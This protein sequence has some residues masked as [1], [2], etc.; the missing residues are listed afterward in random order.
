MHWKISLMVLLTGALIPI[1][2]GINGTL[3]RKT[4]NPLL[5]ATASFVIGTIFLLAVF[6]MFGGQLPKLSSL[7][8]EPWW[9]WTGGAVGALYVLLIILAV[10]RTGAAALIVFVVA[11]QMIASLVIDHYGLIGFPPVPISPQRIFGALLLIGG[12]LV[13]RST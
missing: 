8:G 12:V 9:I 13:I 3:A 6:P 7:R 5:A 10:Q 4:G 2:A 1:Q 11:G